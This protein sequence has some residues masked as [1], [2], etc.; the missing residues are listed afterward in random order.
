MQS[1]HRAFIV[2]KEKMEFKLMKIMLNRMLLNV[3]RDLEHVDKGKITLRCLPH[4]PALIL[5]KKKNKSYFPVIESIYSEMSQN[6]N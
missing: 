3:I 2:A 5:S 4:K 6:T 1:K